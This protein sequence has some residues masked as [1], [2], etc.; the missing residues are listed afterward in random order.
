MTAY[1][2]KCFFEETCYYYYRIIV[3]GSNCL[4]W[5]A[6][7]ALSYVQYAKIDYKII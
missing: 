7:T 3:T 5:N 4:E 2:N 6:I 1:N